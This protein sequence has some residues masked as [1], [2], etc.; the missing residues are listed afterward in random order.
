MDV[1]FQMLADHVWVLKD[2]IDSLMSGPEGRKEN[3]VWTNLLDDMKVHGCSPQQLI[4][5]KSIPP[6]I[7]KAARPGR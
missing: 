4:K 3:F 5:G 1:D 2:V 7:M 6:Q